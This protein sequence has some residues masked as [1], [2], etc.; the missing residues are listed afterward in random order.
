MTSSSVLSAD[1]QHNQNYKD[2]TGDSLRVAMK[3]H[4]AKRVEEVTD[5][6]TDE[7]LSGGGRMRRRSTHKRPLAG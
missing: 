6:P 3:T 5:V 7:R 2:A 4:Q 1:F